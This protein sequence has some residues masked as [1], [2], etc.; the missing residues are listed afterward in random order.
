MAKLWGD[1]IINGKK[2]FGQVPPLLKEPVREY[3]ISV[4]RED[5]IEE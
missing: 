4:G 1:Q 5:L 3:L 2:T